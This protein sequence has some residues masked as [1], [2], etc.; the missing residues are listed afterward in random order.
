MCHKFKDP[1]ILTDF[2]KELKVKQLS[3]EKKKK[4]K[5]SLFNEQIERKISEIRSASS[6]SKSKRKKKMHNRV[7]TES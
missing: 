4:F 7:H 3:H 1:K 2:D 5:N 6:Q